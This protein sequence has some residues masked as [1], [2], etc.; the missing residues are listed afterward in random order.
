MKDPP[1]TRDN[2]LD[3]RIQW[4]STDSVWAAVFLRDGEPWFLEGALVGMG[5]TRGE[6]VTDLCEIAKYL[7]THGANF[8]SEYMVSVEDRVW[9]FDKLDFGD[10]DDEMYKAIR[11]LGVQR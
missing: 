4:H 1:M 6:A 5:S 11:A 10:T 9:L 8:L 2:N 3:I 7:V